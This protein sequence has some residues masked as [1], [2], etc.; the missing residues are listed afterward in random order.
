MFSDHNGDE[1]K[2]VTGNLGI[3]Q[4][5]SLLNN[6]LLKITGKQN[7]PEINENKNNIPKL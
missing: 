4:I 5:Y 6:I 2:K 7:T 3:V 1:M